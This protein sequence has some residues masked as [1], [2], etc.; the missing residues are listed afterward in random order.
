MSIQ[1]GELGVLWLK[2]HF[3]VLKNPL[4][5]FKLYPMF[6]LFQYEAMASRN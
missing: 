6:H 4:S 3:N 5:P 1:L 2:S